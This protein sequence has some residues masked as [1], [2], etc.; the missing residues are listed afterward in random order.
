MDASAVVAEI[1][2]QADTM[3]DMRHMFLYAVEQNLRDVLSALHDVMRE[4][5][6]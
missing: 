3:A 4:H 5:D 2:K 6:M 1:V